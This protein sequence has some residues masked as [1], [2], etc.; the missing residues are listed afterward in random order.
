MRFVL[1]PALNPSDYMITSSFKGHR[2]WKARTFINNNSSGEVGDMHEVGYIMINLTN[3]TIIPISRGD[4]HHQGT[5]LLYEMAA[6]K[7]DGVDGKKLNPS[8]FWP[9]WPYSNYIYDERE[10]E[11]LKIV[12]KKALLYG[13]PDTPIMGANNYRGKISM[14]SDFAKGEVFIT[15]VGNLNPIGKRIYDALETVSKTILKI[16]DDNDRIKTRQ[17]FLESKEFVKILPSMIR[18]KLGVANVDYLKII[19]KLQKEND[20]KGLTELIFGF[21]GIK[22]QMHIHMKK[23]NVYY[24]DELEGIWGDIDLAID[25]LA[26]L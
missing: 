23:N 15:N 22:N 11:S 4:E 1:H 18:V 20:I 24:K 2:N 25:M 8:E 17:A 13:N 14:L 6:G 26:R 21:D 10:I 7:I 19:Q 5:D 9:L 12:A 3:N 16:D